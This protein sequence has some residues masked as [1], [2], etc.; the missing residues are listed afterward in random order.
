MLFIKLQYIGIEGTVL[1]WLKAFLTNRSSSSFFS[2]S[3]RVPQGSVL[4]PLLFPIYINHI[5]SDLHSNVKKFADDLKL[6]L[7]I[8]PTHLSSAL[9]DISVVQRDINTLIVVSGSWDLR[10]IASKTKSLV[11]VL[12]FVILLI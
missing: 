3:S 8:K 12:I 4:G 9:V 2:V 1:S 11:L 6:Y 5:S 7:L 10:V